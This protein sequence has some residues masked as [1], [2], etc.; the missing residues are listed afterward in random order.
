MKIAN[1]VWFQLLICEDLLLFGVLDDFKLNI[2]PFCN[3]AQTKQNLA[4]LVI[5]IF[6]YSF[7]IL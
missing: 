4:E 1:I 2:W 6:N 7:D 3:L 5:G